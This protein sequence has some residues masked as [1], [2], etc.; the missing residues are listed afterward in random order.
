[1]D[2]L[3]IGWAVAML[4]V[5]GGFVSPARA[6]DARREGLQVYLGPLFSRLSLG[7]DFDGQHLLFNRETG[8]LFAFIS[9]NGANLQNSKQN[10]GSFE[11]SL[12]LHLHFGGHNADV[13]RHPQPLQVET[14]QELPVMILAAAV[15]AA[16]PPRPPSYDP[17]RGAQ[18]SGSSQTSAS[19]NPGP[20]VAPG[21]SPALTIAD[22]IKELDDELQRQALLDRL[23][24]EQVRNA[25]GD[26]RRRS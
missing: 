3:R 13:P 14:T 23:H 16:E 26:R 2:K 20:S 5:T 4:M 24:I 19:Q 11:P 17:K 12:A 25:I 15:R 10:S 1:M 6:E 22:F 9:V 21:P 8:D 18:E 7:G